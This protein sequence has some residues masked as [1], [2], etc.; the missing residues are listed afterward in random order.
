MT[1][2]DN[3]LK[4]ISNGD[5]MT[6]SVRDALT[7]VGRGKYS[8]KEVRLAVTSGAIRLY[9]LAKRDGYKKIADKFKEIIDELQTNKPTTVYGVEIPAAD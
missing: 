3:L 5:I 8:L 2:E 6:N 1:M 4:D 7:Y 9:A